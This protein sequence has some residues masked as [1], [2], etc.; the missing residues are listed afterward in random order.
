MTKTLEI[1][2]INNIGKM[3]SSLNTENWH[4]LYYI[5]FTNECEHNVMNIKKEK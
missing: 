1:T 5:K 3:M 2:E 4:T